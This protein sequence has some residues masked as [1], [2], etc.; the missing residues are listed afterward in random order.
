MVR[1]ITTHVISMYSSAPIR[2]QII[3]IIL[4]E[5]FSS[6]ARNSR[7]DFLIL[8]TILT[9][10]LPQFSSFNACHCHAKILFQFPASW[11][12]FQLCSYVHI[13]AIHMYCSR[14]SWIIQN[15]LQQYRNALRWNLHC[16]SGN[17]INLSDLMVQYHY[18]HL[19]REC[20]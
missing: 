15:E 18:N 3:M 7:C 17:A 12:T 4:I 20:S 13:C 9:E 10:R 5:M 11:M 6:Y 2:K 16:K 14:I 8:W 19:K 1:I